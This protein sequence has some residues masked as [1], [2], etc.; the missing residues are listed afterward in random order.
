M[1]EGLYFGGRHIDI[2]GNKLEIANGDFAEPGK[3]M[4]VCV[5]THD[6]ELIPGARPG[7][8][9]NMLPGAVRSHAYLGGQEVL[10]AARASLHMAAGEKVSVRF[11][12]ERC[13]GL[14]R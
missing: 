1:L 12:A 14:V 3:P 2:G 10:I 9:N 13:R 7:P 4:A 5:K 11:P 6:L 8:G